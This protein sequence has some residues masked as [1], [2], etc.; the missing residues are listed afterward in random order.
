MDTI[1]QDLRYALRSL[2]KSPGYTSVA[3]LVLALGIGV[4]TAVFSVLNGVV[5]RPLRYDDAD[6]IYGIW[7]RSERGDYRLASFPTFRDWQEQSDVFEA[8]A[9]MRGTSTLTPGDAGARQVG[10]AFV[11]QQFFDALRGPPLLGRTFSPEEQEPGGPRVAVL[12]HALWQ[13]RFGGDRAILG[14]TIR[15]DQTPYTIVGIL[16]PWFQF[17]SWAEV[18]V[19]LAVI[20]PTDPILAQRGFHADS[21]V[22]VKLKPGV[23]VAQAQG[24]MAGIQMRLAAAYPAESRG[25]TA[26]ELVSLFEEELRFGAIRPILLLLTA[27]VAVVLLLACANVANMS[28]ARAATRA[29]EFAIRAALG[30]GRRRVARLL[31]AESAVLA[32][33]GGALGLLLAWWGI[34][35]LRAAAPEELPR[36]AEI[37]VDAAMLGVT[38]LISAVVTGLIG[39]APALRATARDLT[40]PLK[41]GA[42]SAGSGGIRSRLRATLVALEVALA[43]VLLIGTGLLV[44]SL[45]ML[46]RVNPGFDASGVATVPIFPPSPRYDAPD[47]AIALFGR[48]AEA[49]AA[50]PGVEQV[51]LSNHVPLSGASLPRPIEIPGRPPDP[52]GGEQVLFRTISEQYFDVMRIPLRQGRPFTAG[53]IAT[54]AQVA[55]INETLARRYWPDQNPI[56]R[57]VTLFKSSQSRADFGERFAAQIVGVVGDVRHTGLEEEPAPEV[58]IPYTVNPWAWMNV[59]ARTAGDPQALIP[60][61]QRTVAAVDPDIPVTGRQRPGAVDDLVS[62]QLAR[63]RL[64]ATL[65]SSFAAG[66]L[67]LA[68]LG[69]YGVIAYL[70]AMRT[71]EIGIRAALGATRRHLTGHVVAESAK[72]VV[73]GLGVGLAAAFGLTRL[74]ANLLYGVGTTDAITFTGVTV[75]LGIV[76]LLATYI[77]ARRAARVDP[78][79]ALRAE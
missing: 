1:T 15:L 36:V 74:M 22:I 47:R 57:F 19:P 66:A 51:A 25:W 35:L 50:V 45:W 65:L 14:S 6:R 5:L 71:R 34:G 41:A 4:N 40:E 63:R 38:V 11:S 44:R 60:V 28:L 49:V 2:R 16:P 79:V 64:T 30:A 21:R 76:A 26:V 46:S 61:L 10:T 12:T 37:S 69:I 31:L 56:G 72:V 48:V 13:E 17:P 7:E 55:I 78:M 62:G 70:V 3:L 8:M 43:L 68:A 24:A 54:A 52:Q 42:P 39:V 75:F 59:V 58:Y 9:Y 23:S 27:A 77:P 73:I 18:Y 67:L 29:R 53:D 33:G 20:L 32:L